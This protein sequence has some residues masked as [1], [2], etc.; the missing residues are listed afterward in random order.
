MNDTDYHLHVIS[1][2]VPYPAN[3][4]GVIDVFYRVKALSEAGVKVHLHCFEYGRGEAEV[5]DRCHEVK[6]YKRNTS[7]WKHFH[8]EPYVVA[9]RRSE[10]LVKDLL[11]DDYP[12]LCEGLHTTAVLSDPRFKNRK[13]FVR[14]HNVEHDYYR[15]LAD[16]EPT[17]WKRWFYRMESRKLRRYEPI[18]QKAAG[19]F[20]ITQA[21]T[22]Y[23]NEHYGHAVLV[24]GFSALSRVCS[25]TGRGDYVLYHGNLSVAENK[26]A[27]EWLIE[28]V[29][30][31]LNI[32]CVVAGLNP[33]ES[34]RKLCGR[35][36][37]VSFKAN[38]GDAEMIDLIRNAQI[39]V[40][41][42]DQPTG[43]KLK[44]LNALY[45]GRFCLVNDDMVRGTALGS[46]C[47]VAEEPGQ[48]V[49]E[50]NRL[51]KEDFT[52]DDI[53]ER[54]EALKELYQNDNNAQIIIDTIFTPHS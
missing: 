10:A 23:F 17:L 51:M 31:E 19:I 50:I 18:L 43:L 2:D 42:T 47:V 39:N 3:Y 20:A 41:V 5:F 13:I 25:E 34:L 29:F 22:D 44:L 21:D 30:S 35:Y 32:P 53:A 4:G 11:K 12:I 54:D 38:P 24:P 16:S 28:N 49:A 46:L 48:F 14:A 33:P 27:A 6:Y 7:F 26:K 37:H 52:E 9:S 45:N 1:F 40:M 8:C 15:L 36:P